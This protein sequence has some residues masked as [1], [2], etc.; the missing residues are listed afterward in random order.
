MNTTQHNNTQERIS[1]QSSD[2]DFF[3]LN[4]MIVNAASDLA[5][6]IFELSA[7]PCRML[8]SLHMYLSDLYE[9]GR[10]QDCIDFL[11]IVFG[12]FGL[13]YAEAILPLQTSPEARRHFIYEFSA[14]LLELAEE[15]SSNDAAGQ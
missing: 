2:P 5:E 13:E 1:G 11:Y 10:E 6:S 4:L 9:Q 12:V 3:M 14:E 8:S 7:D 15:L